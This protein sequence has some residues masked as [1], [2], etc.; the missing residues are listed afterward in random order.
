MLERILEKLHCSSINEFFEN[1]KRVWESLRG[2]EA[3]RENP[4][5]QLTEEEMEYFEK[6]ILTQL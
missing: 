2:L 4:L 5:L 6:E 3:E 1:E